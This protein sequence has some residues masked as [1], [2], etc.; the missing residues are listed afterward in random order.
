MVELMRLSR[1]AERG[2]RRQLLVLALCCTSMVVVVM[3][4]SIVNVALPAIGRD[5]HA[6]VADLQW[7][8][9]AYTLVLGSFLVVAGSAADRAGRRRVFRLGL[10]CF[11]LGS[12][13]CSLAPSIG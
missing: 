13:A 4:V 7:T 1:P 9:D 8:V 6:S 10:A 12:L 5:M 11:G 2:R 3:D